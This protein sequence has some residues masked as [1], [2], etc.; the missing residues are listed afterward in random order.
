MCEPTRRWQEAS[1]PTDRRPR[2]AM[3]CRPSGLIH[4]QQVRSVTDLATPGASPRPADRAAPLKNCE[5]R[6]VWR[7]RLRS[8]DNVHVAALDDPDME[9]LLYLVSG[10]LGRLTRFSYRLEEGKVSRWAVFADFMHRKWLE[11]AQ[12]YRAAVT[13]AAVVKFSYGAAEAA[14]QRRR[15][16][17]EEFPHSWDLCHRTANQFALALVQEL[18]RQ[19]GRD[20]PPG[21]SDRHVSRDAS[22]RDVRWRYRY[23]TCTAY[24]LTADR[25]LSAYISIPWRG[26]TLGFPIK[27][28]LF[29]E[30][31][32]QLLPG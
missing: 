26:H 30:T 1:E 9:V 2:H 14:W 21:R 5:T 22:F 18:C 20:V 11:F 10:H 6:G 32:E 27:V 31:V 19:F 3:G 12:W 4:I 29:E 8:C 7:S 13:G 17:W 23:P 28:A 24:M 25:R 15:R 16:E